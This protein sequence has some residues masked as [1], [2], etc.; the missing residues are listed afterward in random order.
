M[1]IL[2]FTPLL[3]L[4]LRIQLIDVPLSDLFPWLTPNNLRKNF[5]IFPK[6]FNKFPNHLILLLQP[7]FLMV[8]HL[9]QSSKSMKALVLIPVLHESWDRTP[10][11]WEFFIEADEQ[12]ILLSIPCLNFP[13]F[14]LAFLLRHQNLDCVLSLTFYH[15]LMNCTHLL[16]KIFIKFIIPCLIFRFKLCLLDMFII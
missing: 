1:K 5:P 11:L 8:T 2:L 16:W 3:L 15:E 12:I 4:N 7:N 10:F 13:F 6:L 9:R 14:P